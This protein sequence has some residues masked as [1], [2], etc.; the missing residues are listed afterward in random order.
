MK[1]MF[2]F[3]YRWQG[4]IIK[5]NLALSAWEALASTVSIPRW[6]VKERTCARQF[7]MMSQFSRWCRRGISIQN[8]PHPRYR[9]FNDWTRLLL[10]FSP[11][12][13]DIE[14]IPLGGGT[15]TCSTSSAAES[16]RV[17]EKNNR[18]IRWKIHV[19]VVCRLNHWTFFFLFL[20]L[21]NLCKEWT[22]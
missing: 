21:V 11:K 15:R 4:K 20:F 10:L 16:T 22:R 8:T 13:C 12:G 19:V 9:R 2:V 7:A 1:C 17:S 3:N 5:L 6:D 18:H 14:G